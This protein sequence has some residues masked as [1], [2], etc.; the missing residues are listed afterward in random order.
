VLTRWKPP[1]ALARAASVADVVIT[2]GGCRWAGPIREG[3]DSA[4][5]NVEDATDNRSLAVGEADFIGLPG[6]GVGLRHLLP[7]RTRSCPNAWATDVLYR[8]FAV[9]SDF[10]RSAARR[11][12][13]RAV[14]TSGRPALGP[15]RLGRADLQ[16]GDGWLTSAAVM[17]QLARLG[18]IHSF[19]GV[20]VMKLHVLYFARL[21]NAGLARKPGFRGTTAA[22]LIAQLQ[23]RGGIW[24]EELAAG[25]AFRVAVNQDIVTL[26]AVLP[27]SAEVAIFPPVTG[28]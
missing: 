20:A 25:R 12:P 5:R 10:A 2:S 26:D 17:P 7:V 15:A 14:S 18:S 27:D 1:A 24:A 3:G 21:R 22:D 19:L 23:A 16:P 28:G 4:R 6:T 9:Q 11:E 13:G 8:A